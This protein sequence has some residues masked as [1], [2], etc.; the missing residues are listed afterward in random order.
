M[1]K[2]PQIE[3][4]ME[5]LPID[6]LVPFINNPRTITASQL[7]RMKRSIR[8]DGY[9]APIIA[10]GG[11]PHTIAAGHARWRAL[12][13]MGFT[14]V[15]VMLPSRPLTPEEF[16]RI[17][18]RDNLDIGEWDTKLLNQHFGLDVLVDLGMPENILDCL[19]EENAAVNVP[20]GDPDMVLPT[21]SQPVTHAGDLYEIGPHRILC[22]DSTLADNLLKLVG[23]ARIDLLLTDQ[24]Y[25]VA[26]EG[27]T[28]DALTI[29]NDSMTDEEFRSFLHKAFAAADLVMKKGAVFYIWHAD[30]EGFN[31]RGAC[32]DVDWKVRECLIWVKNTMVLG[33]QDYQWQHEPCLYG[34]KEGAPH[35]WTSDRKQTTLLN[36]D[37]PSRSSEHPT[38]KPVALMEYQLK[39]NTH[40][41]GNVLDLFGGSGSTIVATHQAGRRGFTIELDPRYV[42][43]I[44]SRMLRLFPDLRE[45]A[46]LNG[47]PFAAPAEWNID[48]S[49]KQ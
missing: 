5:Q 21:P 27:K 30:S 7:E 16:K 4:H 3:W 15:N 33:R 20:A 49:V 2:M 45:G 34:W 41:D 35:L 23:E 19:R 43:V 39:N 32:R 17:N 48:E 1:S 13:D 8:E 22:G 37:R 14:V 9:H 31:F 10:D 29:Q 11:S 38:M 28:K 36:F 18:I 46:K 44:V 26:Y 42:D 47:Q 24:P 12:R 6:H 40:P 25:N